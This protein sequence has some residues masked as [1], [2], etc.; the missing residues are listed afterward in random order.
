MQVQ[1]LQDVAA[2]GLDCVEADIKQCG[3]RLVRLPFG[4]KLKYLALTVRKQLIAIYRTPLFENADVVLK[5]RLTLGLKKDL[6][7]E[8]AFDCAD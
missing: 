2:M 1:F 6:P 5:I 4:Q 7:C 3:Y 8:T